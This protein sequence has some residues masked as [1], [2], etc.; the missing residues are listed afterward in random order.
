MGPRVHARV[1]VARLRVNGPLERG[2]DEE[3]GTDE[4]EGN[5]EEE[6]HEGEEEDELLGPVDETYH[7]DIPGSLLALAR[8][9][10]A[11]AAPDCTAISARDWLLRTARAGVSAAAARCCHETAAS[12]VAERARS[13]SWAAAPRGGGRAPAV[14]PQL[15]ERGVR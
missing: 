2:I 4:E 13:W 7:G 5:K 14:Y 8:A 3:L 11:G 1:V 12:L 10:S 15:R 9:A 6:G